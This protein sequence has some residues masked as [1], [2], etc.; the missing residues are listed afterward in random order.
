MRHL[1]ASLMIATAVLTTAGC[2]F[3]TRGTTQIPAEMKTMILN[4][5]DPYGPL[6]RTVREQLR[7]SGINLVEDD[8]QQRVN[9]PT[10]RLSDEVSNR[11]TA[12]VF[13]DGSRAEYQLILT[14][15]AQVLIPGSGIYPLHTSVYRSYFDNSGVPL[16]ADSQQDLIYKEMRERA[17]QQLVRQLLAVHAAEKQINGGKQALAQPEVI[18]STPSPSSASGTAI[19]N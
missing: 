12:S 17:A 18:S 7:L 4:S 16:A 1:L 19:D 2:G 11:D 14:V 8:A 10:L 3:H 15:T 5:T 13:L 9:V 6:A